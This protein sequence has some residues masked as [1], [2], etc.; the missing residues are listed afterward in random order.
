[1]TV[2]GLDQDWY[3]PYLELD[4]K[5]S[6]EIQKNKLRINYTFSVA[7]L[8][9]NIQLIASLVQE[10]EPYQLRRG[11][12]LKQEGLAVVEV[13]VSAPSPVR[14]AHVEGFVQFVSR[15]ADPIR[16]FSVQLRD[17]GQGRDLKAD[18]G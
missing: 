15:G 8:R 14:N 9:P 7:S 6:N 1:P 16:A 12:I 13:Q 2:P 11:T 10:V 18:D 4:P 3:T 5:V 17:D